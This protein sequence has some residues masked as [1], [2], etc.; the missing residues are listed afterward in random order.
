MLP[1]EI[2]CRACVGTID[3]DCDRGRLSGLIGGAELEV[4]LLIVK[5]GR[6]VAPAGRSTLA[7]VGLEW[8]CFA[9]WVIRDRGAR[10]DLAG[11]A[12]MVTD[13]QLELLASADPRTNV[14]LDEAVLEGADIGTVRVG[15]GR[16]ELEATLELD[17]LVDM[18]GCPSRLDGRVTPLDDEDEVV[19]DADKGRCGGPIVPTLLLKIESNLPRTAKVLLLSL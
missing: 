14:E 8:A 10:A 11:G 16:D 9:G 12:E 2:A 3:V 6:M 5:E 18:I 13:R 15:A 17:A 1:I 19:L 7:S 4:D